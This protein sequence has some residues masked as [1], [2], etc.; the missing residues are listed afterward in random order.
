MR[1]NMHSIKDFIEK[2]DALGG[3]TTSEC[4]AYWQ[5]LVYEPACPLDAQDEP[6]SQ[7]YKA[8]Q[9]ALYEEITGHQYL[10]KRDEFTPG[11]PVERLL[12]APNAC[13]HGSPADY[14][15]HCVAMGLL[16]KQL[17][18]PRG[19]RILELGS[20]WGFSQEFLSQCGFDTVGLDANPDFV[21]TSNARLQRL[22]FGARVVQSTFE[23]ISPDTLGNFDAIVAY[24]AFHH[25]VDPYSVLRK[26]VAC[27]K[28]EGVFAIAGEPFNNYYR[29][30]GLRHDC[31]SIYCIRKFGWF[32]SGWSV[33]YMAD[34]F[35]RCGMEAT[36]ADMGISELTTFMLGRVANRRR[37][38]QLGM[39]HPDNRECFYTDPKYACCKGEGRIT[40]HIPEGISCLKVNLT[41]FNNESLMFDLELD[42]Q[43]IS[44]TAPSGVATVSW[45]LVAAPQ[46]RKSIL[47]VRSDLFCPM[48][49]GINSDS[50]M[51][52]IY[53]ESIEYM[54]EQE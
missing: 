31:L 53:I 26:A 10:D 27:L 43:L 51:L 17:A 6:L 54:K 8:Q 45:K 50:R 40:L 18:L 29:T 23:D 52:G 30:W 15:K 42:G 37:A 33:E 19:A 13:D 24:E 7:R 5:D 14:A 47:R 2:S 12:N 22:G 3:P 36:F 48:H 32:E 49:Q 28:P 21:A 4:K 46:Q 41:N 38:F 34:L 1:L 20:G 16:V 35:G 44:T 9:L 25:A 11:V 39:W